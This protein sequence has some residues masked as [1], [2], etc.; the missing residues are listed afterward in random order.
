MKAVNKDSLRILY[1]NIIYPYYRES[2][3]SSFLTSNK[4]KPLTSNYI[5]FLRHYIPA[6]LERFK[7]FFNEK[8]K[9]I[10]IS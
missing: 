5:R 1:W 2:N 3:N 4:F 8:C 7:Y 9:Q 10:S 6:K